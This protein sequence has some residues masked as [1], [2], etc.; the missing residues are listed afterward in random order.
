MVSEEPSTKVDTEAANF[1]LRLFVQYCG[2]DIGVAL[3]HYTDL[4]QSVGECFLPAIQYA[5]NIFPDSGV[6]TF[7]FHPVRRLLT[8]GC[9]LEEVD[10]FGRSALLA[11]V[12]GVKRNHL[13]EMVD[14]L[15]QFGANPHAVDN[16]DAGILH[17]ILRTTSACN[18]AHTRQAIFQPIKNIVVKLLLRGCNPNAVD[19]DDHTPSDLAL[20]SSAWL[21]WCDALQAAGLAPDGVLKEDDRI[22]NVVLD[23][24][25]LDGKYSEWLESLPPRCQIVRDEPSQPEQSFPVCSYCQYPDEWTQT[26][27]PFDCN[28]T[29]MVQMGSSFAHASFV[30]HTDGSWCRN[31]SKW[32]SCRRKCH[33]K[34]GGF[35]YWS[36]KSLSI[37][38]HIAYRLWKDRVLANPAQAYAWATCS[39]NDSVAS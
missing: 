36:W 30:N 14:L 10:G 1:A 12:G 31:G 17:Y 35:A 32:M 11:S 22:H 25:L 38:K 33:R 4:G 3:K 34:D 29:Y 18:R 21:L 19:E 26:R 27:A 23:N 13:A 6:Q 24:V 20:S 15:L 39:L 5:M 37:R 9:D 7:L 28:G 16:G 8:S 2:P